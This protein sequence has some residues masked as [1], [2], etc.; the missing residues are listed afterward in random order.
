MMPHRATEKDRE[1]V[2]AFERFE[3]APDAFD[4]RAHNRMAYTYLCEHDIET[5]SRKIRHALCGFL[6]HIGVAPESKYHET[7]TQAWVLTVR[8]FMDRTEVS[9]SAFEFIDA[10]PALLDTGILAAHY[11]KGVLSSDAARNTF[12]EPD[13][14]PIPRDDP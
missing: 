14:T 13:L 9:N 5:T 1:F 12:V 8:H 7:M 3:I 11:S 10:N 2:R 6:R 4:H